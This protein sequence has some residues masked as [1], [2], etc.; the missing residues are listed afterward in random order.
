MEYNIT[1]DE[2]RDNFDY[3]CDKASSGSI[4]KVSTDNGIIVVVS[5]NEYNKSIL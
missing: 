2:F 3:Y 1:S 5:E 4:I